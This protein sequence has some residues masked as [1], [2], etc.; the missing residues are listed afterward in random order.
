MIH[1]FLLSSIF[2]DFC[3]WNR[4]D[5]YQLMVRKDWATDPNI[6]ILP[7]RRRHAFWDRVRDL[8]PVERDE[9]IVGRFGRTDRAACWVGCVCFSDWACQS[10]ELLTTIY[11][12]WRPQYDCLWP[13]L[14]DKTEVNPFR[15]RRCR[16]GHRATFHS[17]YGNKISYCVVKSR[18]ANSQL[19]S[20]TLTHTL[21]NPITIF[22]NSFF[23]LLLL[24]CFSLLKSVS[25]V[26]ANRK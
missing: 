17:P 9:P 19:A 23:V 25:F 5:E 24:L 12:K 8:N 22:S 26:K 10:N 14:P 20:Y 3:C 11:T 7:D 21:S 2:F 1:D 15:R 16:D 6:R 13:W 4:S 18:F